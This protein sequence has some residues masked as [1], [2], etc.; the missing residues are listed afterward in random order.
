MTEPMSAREMLALLMKAGQEASM[1]AIE[2]ELANYTYVGGKR[3]RI[4]PLPEL[5]ADGARTVHRVKVAL[6]GSRP[7]VW[8]RLDIPSAMPLDKVHEV[9]QVAFDWYDLHLHSFETPSGR[10]GSPGR[11]EWGEPD[12]DETTAALG[13]VAGAEKAKVVY[14]YDFGDDWRHDI[15]VE[16]ILPA[17]QSVAYPRCITGRGQAPAEDSGGIWA[18]N[19]AT[20]EA[21]SA[22]P[23][24]PDEVTEA[25][26]ALATV[27][28]T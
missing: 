17:T 1:A 19:E 12:L 9:L 27:L 26:A 23:F 8:R 20:E 10:F 2:A 22:E 11:D 15:V 28:V 13:Q 24:D 21:G 25:L 18:A 5:Q 14:V 16:K 6:Y 3:V 7:P 4:Q